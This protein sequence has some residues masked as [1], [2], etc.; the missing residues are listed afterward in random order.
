M[1]INGQQLEDSHTLIDYH[2]DHGST[3]QLVR[4]SENDIERLG[5]KTSTLKV[6]LTDTIE[7]CRRET[8]F[9]LSQSTI[10]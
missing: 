6:K 2:I 1:K 10:G 8:T 7:N 4:R 3:L 9:D 5:G